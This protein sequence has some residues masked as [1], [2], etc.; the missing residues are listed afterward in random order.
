MEN[1]NKSTVSAKSPI[2][3]PT[4]KNA[5]KKCRPRIGLHV[6]EKGPEN[7]DQKPIRAYRHDI[8]PWRAAPKG[9]SFRGYSGGGI[10]QVVESLTECRV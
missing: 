9:V 6:P 4:R 5:L 8:L 2:I 10:A 7:Q 3:R 1:M